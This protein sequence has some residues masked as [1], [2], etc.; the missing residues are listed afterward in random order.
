ML[1]EIVSVRLELPSS[2]GVLTKRNKITKLLVGEDS[3]QKKKDLFMRHLIIFLCLAYSC[4][5]PSQETSLISHPPQEILDSIRAKSKV[6][7]ILLHHQ[8]QKKSLVSKMVYT[9]KGIDSLFNYV[10]QVSTDTTCLQGGLFNHFGQIDLFTDSSRNEKVAEMHFVLEGN[11]ADFYL[12]TENYLK[13]YKM[14]PEGN[15]FLSKLFIDNKNSL[16]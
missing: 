14:A 7:C 16:R 5:N 12:K 15:A 10:E 8:V 3:N 13:R 2:V 11:C 6:A 9:R 1:A 4:T